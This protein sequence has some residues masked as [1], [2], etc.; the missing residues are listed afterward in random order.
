MRRGAV[1]VRLSK[2][3]FLGSVLWLSFHGSTVQAQ[4]TVRNEDCLDC[5]DSF[6]HTKFLSSAHKQN[7]C[8]DCH[9]GIKELPHP[10]TIAPVDCSGCH[11][12]E[13]EAY[14]HSHHGLAVKMGKSAASCLSCHGQPHE[15]LSEGNVNS[16]IHRQNVPNTCGKCHENVLKTYAQSVH[17]K[18]A[19]S[20]KRE[21]P[22]C[23][24]CHGEHTIKSHLDP[25]S[26]VYTSTV[27]EKVCA[28]CHAAEQIISKYGLPGNRVKTYL[29][30]Y[31]GLAGRYGSMTVANCASC[32]GAHNILPSND[33][34]SSVNRKNLPQTCGRCHPNVSEQLAQGSIHVTPSLS[35]DRKIYFVTLFYIFLI[36]LV[37]GGM[38]LHNLIDFFAKLKTHYRRLK[39]ETTYIKFTR[40]ERIQHAVL[41]ISFTVL[42]Y[43]GFALKF[44][45][46]WWAWPFGLIDVK[47]DLRG[48]IHR[49]AALVFVV[50]GVYHT[51][52]ALFTRRGRLQVKLFFPS[53]KDFKDF[54]KNIRF[55]L[56][57]SKQKPHFGRYGYIE[58]VEYWALLWGSLI[59]M[60]TGA[61]L[62][63]ENWAMR[64]FPKWV[65]DVA[66]TI[67]FYEAVL[68]TLAI[69]VWHFYFTIFDPDH[70]PMNWSMA[71][72]R[73]KKEP[74][75]PGTPE[76]PFDSR[77]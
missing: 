48:V 52:I 4:E 55:N 46:A 58:K 43:T 69:V 40:N 9:Q 65:M 24:D 7:Q 33:S 44:P 25:A 34:N 11:K 3:L 10:E 68:A 54:W 60:L 63:F 51:L 62:T 31:H 74:P 29:E 67:H 13:A 38:V 6:N 41:F 61:I 18:A 36:M 15:L 37:I 35:R 8:T 2:L 27:S 32:H 21:A 66:V 26:S 19:M 70:Y 17:G 39:E 45:D 73:S 14:N 12:S 56:G 77:F 76:K 5:H 72:G 53:M 20:G 28:R 23:T 16:P 22:V 75:S 42:A 57:L 59:M 64:Y 1:S 30:S 71:T 50:L 47:F 49:G